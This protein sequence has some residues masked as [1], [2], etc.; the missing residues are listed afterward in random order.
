MSD[1]D[2][3]SN[4]AMVAAVQA[5]MPDWEAVGSIINVVGATLLIVDMSGTASCDHSVVDALARAYQRAAA[6]ARS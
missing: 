4:A 1:A 5:V 2:G 3:N 6:T